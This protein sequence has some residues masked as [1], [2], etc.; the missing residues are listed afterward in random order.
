MPRRSIWSARQ[1]AAR[2]DR[3][4]EGQHYRMAGLNL[5]AAIVI[6]W[7]TAEGVAAS[8]LTHADSRERTM[9]TAG[10]RRPLSEAVSPMQ[11]D[12]PS[13]TFQLPTLTLHREWLVRETDVDEKTSQ[14][15]CTCMPR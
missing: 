6:Y 2:F 9:P 13:P 14:P 1:R 12:G 7:N 3:S 8:G 4:S 5:L 10:P 11:F 15:I